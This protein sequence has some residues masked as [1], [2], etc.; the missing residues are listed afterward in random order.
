MSNLRPI[1]RDSA[2]LLGEE[3]RRRGPGA[4]LWLALRIVGDV[5]RT[6]S[7]SLVHLVAPGRGLRALGR[8]VRHAGRRLRR[9]GGVTATTIAIVAVATGASIAIAGVV[10]AA[11]FDTGGIDQ[12]SRVVALQWSNSRMPTSIYFEYP[13]YEKMRATGVFERVAASAYTSVPCSCDAEGRPVLVGLVT[14]EF[15]GVFG[16]SPL[17]G[18]FPEPSER[19]GVVVSEALARERFGGVDGAVGQSV[20]IRDGMFVIVG[21]A[22]RN[23]VGP[24]LGV[25]PAVWVSMND[26]PDVYL[27]PKF[28]R[29]LWP[30]L[31]AA[32]GFSWI[33]VWGRLAEG[34][35]MEVARQRLLPLHGGLEVVDA[36]SARV[37]PQ[38]RDV[39]ARFLTGLGAVAV[40]LL[41]LC[42]A[43]LMQVSLLH[44]ERS[45]PEMAL[46]LSL[47][48][49][50]LAVIAAPVLDAAAIVAI[51]GAVGFAIAPI[52]LKGFLL[53]LPPTTVPIA[54]SVSV[55]N[56]Q[57][58]IVALLLLAVLAIFPPIVACVR[59]FRRRREAGTLVGGGA[60]VAGAGVRRAGAAA[61][62]LQTTA[63]A[64][65]VAIVLLVV[66]GLIAYRRA[67][68]GFRPEQLMIVDFDLDH[69]NLSDADGIAF[70][71]RLREAL[72]SAPSVASATFTS[73]APVNV[74]G[75]SSVL[76]L[77]PR[78]RSVTYVDTTFVDANF[79]DVL[80][81]PI[82]SG[83][84]R[85]GGQKD[86]LVINEQYVAMQNEWRAKE[87][88]ST[89]TRWTAAVV[90]DVRYG[91]I[92]GV[93]NPTSYVRLEDRYEPRVKALVRVTADP[94]LASA[95]LRQALSSVSPDLR[96]TVIRPMAANIAVAEWVPRALLRVIGLF[97]L[98]AVGVALAGTFAVVAFVGQ[99]RRREFAIRAALGASRARVHQL[100]LAGLAG[101]IVAGAVA[102]GV[103]ATQVADLV[104]GLVG[105][106]GGHQLGVV[107]IATL[108]CALFGCLA[109][110][111]GGS[112]ARRIDLGQLLKAE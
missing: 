101:P 112:L 49:P 107:T 40:L 57:T 13:V 23:F 77:D 70:T 84:P 50:V 67:D 83:V 32:E 34:V 47:G 39:T 93:V 42:A 3:W 14:D 89:D 58:G 19:R 16:V 75:R 24:F 29:K 108:S 51:G 10:S 65:L 31:R 74:L 110:W 80:E 106:V 87:L 36:T 111:L 41:V 100:S 73:T 61:V 64:S 33:Q 105:T 56:W 91:A 21:V 90:A 28:M 30:N 25:E 94:E 12:P 4:A 96:H 103:I 68:L 22:P 98:V 11:F 7:Q 92:F 60:R 43:A 97:A 20:A 81:V 26:Q 66:A 54:I 78:P 35:S 72:R 38:L 86:P 52:L 15:F 27:A 79:F 85:I 76:G 109:A 17:R 18:R 1:L 62:L 55:V 104:R 63:A 45:V 48:A 46:K 6:A 44:A 82:R 71:N 53:T 69:L 59:L 102:G 9:G 8:E 5:L 88:P 37:A 95:A 2:T 99:C